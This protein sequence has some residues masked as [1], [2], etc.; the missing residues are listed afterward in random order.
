MVTL[1]TTGD[2]I[3]PVWHEL[4]YWLK[5]DGFAR[6]QFKPLVINRYGHCTLTTAEVLFAFGVATQQK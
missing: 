4:L 6:T 5:A 2:P 3:I 1:H